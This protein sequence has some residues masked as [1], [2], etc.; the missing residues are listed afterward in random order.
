M[1][2][3]KPTPAPLPLGDPLLAGQIGWWLAADGNGS[4]LTN[5]A[6][7]NRFNGTLQAGATWSAGD[8]G[9]ALAF[10]GTSTAYV[11]LG[12]T[13]L[14]AQT[15]PFTLLW[16]EYVGTNPG[17][18][19]V[20]TFLPTSAANRFLVFRN[21]SSANYQ[22]LSCGLGS[23]AQACRF[24]AAPTLA[25]GV[26]IWRTFI[27]IGRGGMSSTTTTNWDLYFKS[28]GAG[29]VS[30]GACT[31]AGSGGLSAAASNLNYLGWDGVDNQWNG[32]MENFRLWARAIN[33]NEVNR[34]LADPYAGLRTRRRAP[35]SAGAPAPSS[36]SRAMLMAF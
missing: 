31:L 12:T 2:L 8:T 24:A 26:G 36:S 28:P 13:A 1:P 35:S 11:D 18:P 33:G 34:L 4:R 21:D 20:A 3:A 15:D 5:S 22:Y 27:L 29:T 14:L 19:A 16:R 7:A 30:A 9:R 6:N 23:A 25:S 32:R 17:F 10:D